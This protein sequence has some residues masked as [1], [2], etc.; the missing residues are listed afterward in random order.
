MNETRTPLTSRSPAVTRTLP[1]CGLAGDGRPFLAPGRKRLQGD[2]W[3]RSA[4]KRT[5]ASGAAVAAALSESEVR[6][7][8]ASA[9]VTD[10]SRDP[11]A[12]DPEDTRCPA[13][14]RP[15][16]ARM[17]LATGFSLRRKSYSNRHH[18]P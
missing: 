14:R 6:R 16:R 12:A 2:A 10:S 9:I 7:L 17:L 18:L 5:G 8:R 1:A 15:Q 3:L 13:R 11:L 4:P